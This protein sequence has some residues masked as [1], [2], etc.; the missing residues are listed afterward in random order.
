MAAN[1]YQDWLDEY[2]DAYGV[3][4]SIVSFVADQE[5]GRDANAVSP[6]GA[7]GVMQIMPDTAAQP[8]GEP[9]VREGEDLRNPQVNIRAGTDYL[10]RMLERYDNKL[11]FALAAYNWGPGATDQWIANGAKYSEL[12]EETYNYIQSA[13]KSL[14]G[15]MSAPD[16]LSEVES[17]FGVRAAAYGIDTPFPTAPQ[18]KAAPPSMP[19]EVTGDRT[20]LEL[21]EDTARK[22]G[23][24]GMGLMAAATDMTTSDPRPDDVSFLDQMTAGIASSV[25][26]WAGIDFM[27]E[28]GHTEMA[29]ISKEYIAENERRRA[30]GEPTLEE[31]RKGQVATRAAEYFNGFADTMNEGLSDYQ[32]SLELQM[33]TAVDEGAMATFG[34]LYD[35]PEALIGIIAESGAMIGVTGL[36][37][38]GAKAGTIA[39]GA[40]EKVVR[41][42]TIGTSI[43]TETAVAAGMNAQQAQL[44]IERLPTEVL[45][46][47]PEYQ[48]LLEQG[49]HPD[50]IRGLLRQRAGDATWGFSIVSN[51]V[52]LGMS[53]KLGAN[54]VADVMAGTT[55]KVAGAVS[56]GRYV[57]TRAGFEMGQEFGQETGDAFAGSIGEVVSGVRDPD[58][59]GRGVVGQGIIGAAAGGIMGGA[60][61]MRTYDRAAAQGSIDQQAQ[62]DLVD[63]LNSRPPA[64]PPPPGAAPAPEPQ[65]DA[66]AAQRA[67]DEAWQRQYQAHTNAGASDAA[68]R[69]AADMD[70]EAK[71]AA[72]RAANAASAR[73]WAGQNN[74]PPDELPPPGAPPANVPDDKVDGKL[75]K[76]YKSGDQLILDDGSRVTLTE[77]TARQASAMA[78]RIN[79]GIG[80]LPEGIDMQQLAAAVGRNEQ[81]ELTPG[82]QKQI[83]TGTGT[84]STEQLNLDLA[85]APRLIPKPVYASTEAKQLV[86]LT[87]TQAKDVEWALDAMLP[88]WTDEGLSEQRMESADDQPYY[89]KDKVLPRVMKMGNKYFLKPSP[90]EEINDDLHYRIV[91]Q[92]PGIVDENVVEGLSP[93]DKKKG[94]WLSPAQG[95]ARQTNIN[96]FGDKLDTRRAGLPV[97]AE[98]ATP[99][100]AAPTETTELID[101][102]APRQ[103]ILFTQKGKPSSRG[104]KSVQPATTPATTPAAAEPSH[105]THKMSALQKREMTQSLLPATNLL[106]KTGRIVF[107]K[108][109]VTFADEN[110]ARAVA[111]HIRMTYA[112]DSLVGTEAGTPLKRSMLS[113]AKR[114]E[115]GIA[116]FTAPAPRG[117]DEAN[118]REGRLAGRKLLKTEKGKLKYHDEAFVKRHGAGKYAQNLADVTVKELSQNAFDGVKGAMFHKLLA[119]GVIRVLTDET[120]RTITVIDNGIGMT[121]DTV[122]DAFLTVGGTFKA[123]LPNNQRSGGLGLAKIAFLLGTEWTS[124]RTTRDGITTVIH[125]ATPIEIQAGTFDIEQ[126]EAEPDETGTWVVVKIPE[127]TINSEGDVTVVPWPS[128]LNKPNKHNPMGSF[129]GR[130]MVNDNVTIEFIEDSSEHGSRPMPTNMGDQFNKQNLIDPNADPDYQYADRY[131]YTPHL[132]TLTIPNW[133]VIDIYQSEE[134][135][136]Y[137]WNA[138][139]SVLSS[140]IWQF[141]KTIAKDMQTK[142]PRNI[143]YDIKA[144]VNADSDMYPFDNK[145]EDFSPAVEKIVE[146]ANAFV[147]NYYN[148]LQAQALQKTYQNPLALPYMP[149]ALD[150]PSAFDREALRRTA[151][152]YDDLQA[153]G[154]GQGIVDPAATLKDVKFVNGKAVDSKGHDLFTEEEVEELGYGGEKTTKKVLVPTSSSPMATEFKVQPQ[155]RPDDT[156]QFQNNIG[157]KIIE[158][159]REHGDPFEFFAKLGSIYLDLR[160]MILPAFDE[161]AADWGD[162]QRLWANKGRGLVTEYYV[163]ISIDKDYAGVNIPLPFNAVFLNPFPANSSYHA[164]TPRGKAFAMLDTMLHEFAHVE[165]NSHDADFTQALKRLFVYV[166][167]KDQLDIFLNRIEDVLFG[168]AAM[169]EAMD[170][171][172]NDIFTENVGK[173]LGKSGHY[174]RR[175]PDTPETAGA[176]AQGIGRAE[177]EQEGGGGVPRDVD[178]AGRPGGTEP[179]AGTGEGGTG[180]VVPPIYTPP[181]PPPTGGPI[182]LPPADDKPGGPLFPYNSEPVDPDQ[183]EAELDNGV[184]IDI[185]RTTSRPEQ[186]TVAGRRTQADRDKA[187]KEKR[188]RIREYLY[189][190]TVGIGTVMDY[191]VGNDV[192]E[193]TGSKSL[194]VSRFGFDN[195]PPMPP[196][197][198]FNFSGNNRRRRPGSSRQLAKRAWGKYRTGLIELWQDNFISVYDLQ[199]VLA[200]DSGIVP[201]NWQLH[202]AQTR[203]GVMVDWEFKEV[204]RLYVEPIMK[205][206]T[207]RTGGVGAAMEIGDADELAA[208]NHSPYRNYYVWNIREGRKAGTKTEKELRISPLSGTTQPA[209]SLDGRG[210]RDFDRFG[211]P[212]GVLSSEAKKVMQGLVNRFGDKHLAA[213]EDAVFALAEYQRMWLAPISINPDFGHDLLTTPQYEAWTPDPVFL[214]EYRNVRDRQG[215]MAAHEYSN[216]NDIS[217]HDWMMKMHSVTYVPL[218]DA[219]MTEEQRRLMDRIQQTSKTF[220]VEASVYGDEELAALGRDGK[221]LGSQPISH[222]LVRMQESLVRG[223]RNAEQSKRIVAIIQEIDDPRIGVVSEIVDASSLSTAGHKLT[224]MGNRRRPRFPTPRTIPSNQ[225][226]VRVVHKMGDKEQVALIYDADL[227][228]ALTKQIGSGGANSTVWKTY[229]DVSRVVR[230]LQTTHNPGFVATNP[231]REIETALLQVGNIPGVTP[232]QEADMRAKLLAG[233]MRNMWDW[234][235]EYGKE[236]KTPGV[237]LDSLPHDQ[238]VKRRF[239]RDM[240]KA[241]AHSSAYKPFDEVE[242][243]RELGRVHKRLAKAHKAGDVSTALWEYSFKAYGKWM[244]LAAMATENSPRLIVGY[245]VYKLRRSEGVPH[246]QAINHAANVAHDQSVNFQ[247]VGRLVQAARINK[248]YDYFNPAIQGTARWVKFFASKRGMKAMAALYGIGVMAALINRMLAGEDDDGNNYYETKTP[249][250]KRQ[251]NLIMVIP[252]TEGEHISIPLAY[253]MNFFVGLGDITVSATLGASDR[254]MTVEEAVDEMWPLSQRD[255]INDDPFMVPGEVLNLAMTSF[256]PLEGN[257]LSAG[258]LLSTITPS[259]FSPLVDINLTNRDWKGMPIQPEPYV[260]SPQ[261]VPDSYN[262]RDAM[263]K[264]SLT[265]MSYWVAQSVNDAT[266]GDE[267]S[268]GVIDWSPYSIA[269]QIKANTGGA[270]MVLFRALDSVNYMVKGDW[271]EAARQTPVVRRFYGLGES[272][273]STRNRYTKLRMM[274]EPLRNQRDALVE[275]SG[276]HEDKD[277]DTLQQ[278]REQNPDLNSLLLRLKA[279]E[280]RLSTKNRARSALKDIGR[281]TEAQQRKLEKIDEDATDIMYR[282]NDYYFKQYVR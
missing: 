159:G 39:M 150:A 40:S 238:R 48:K 8:G 74:Q 221:G 280:N 206:I 235:V 16:N 172:Y 58:D 157:P 126:Y 149:S 190:R 228:A 254:Q 49:M 249:K 27:S 18:P 15:T 3:D 92:L 225:E 158:K 43:G 2:A 223:I 229:L 156:I 146:Q 93:A 222:L 153:R 78:R 44:I 265:A 101:D 97:K 224:M 22:L 259:R 84:T 267:F 199:Q 109:Q 251:R 231:F 14:S 179:T 207:T 276:S 47:L 234:T 38:R 239:I 194:G 52:T 244:D 128:D 113:L 129:L 5:S 226:P 33:S 269:Y 64:P 85:R 173:S 123:D 59:L 266:G 258:G 55:K 268:P 9:L 143:V 19:A 82:Q 37:A 278:F 262:L 21:A 165:A 192:R 148:S 104:V 45:G 213:V 57:A 116:E 281:R 256:L 166:V 76:S 169:F 237:D 139:H 111:N 271:G 75:I 130:P 54:V 71:R 36:M 243:Q 135:V 195:P 87:P 95:R 10:S 115:D 260:G 210:N 11:D 245:E 142:I 96:K 264:D 218:K 189:S 140:G 191:L 202:G 89:F 214:N 131:N 164:M 168:H 81:V 236:I 88:Y 250:W 72:V 17:K 282:F 201:D 132:T 42:A 90:V 215:Y 275:R 110:T 26:D 177:R 274:L 209:P 171:V 120:N 141:D 77:K 176:G 193:R 186:P 220:F 196:D 125:E 178:P 263:A 118:L 163:G 66:A 187:D 133:G 107:T 28:Y 204:E 151:N 203:A 122:R 134:D 67:E 114:I 83:A 185:R 99:T 160:Q 91:Q 105:L 34:Y 198:P 23:S 230:E 188:R 184:R 4:R 155:G 35:H 212:S 152:E 1:P 145:R 252:G 117:S 197:D 137:N 53:Q 13:K 167:D 79:S 279:S 248:L 20:W 232:Q 102:T 138:R 124:L 60:M 147:R 7:V 24:G 121:V 51:L 247:R 277:I 86:P 255:L 233:G 205:A 41:G 180:G 106:V 56:P 227:A 127:E 216:Y 100:A 103:S 69:G 50:D 154:E 170:E 25:G 219:S 30:A 208:A 257:A 246:D 98:T 136:K 273:Y 62:D 175:K 200:E 162:K 73:Q 144:D 68:A 65:F 80:V 183:A 182:A 6:K 31:E 253:G 32:K 261:L 241:G 272:R 61:S 46:T 174:E 63:E 181:P 70:K 119:Q 217:F 112:A 108:N 240:M 94:D 242:M 161:N 211:S 29:R 270:G 12:P